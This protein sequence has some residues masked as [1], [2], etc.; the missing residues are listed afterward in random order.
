MGHRA[1]GRARLLE[2]ATVTWAANVS[3]S[4]TVRRGMCFASADG[5]DCGRVAAVLVAGN[6]PQAVALLLHHLP[7]GPAYRRVALAHVA[8]VAGDTVQLALSQ[9]AIARL[10]HWGEPV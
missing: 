6:P 7:S 8:A 4:A 9:E 2:T 10:P 3:S 1:L 5:D